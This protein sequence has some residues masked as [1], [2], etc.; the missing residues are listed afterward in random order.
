MWP[1][2]SN[3]AYVYYSIDKAVVLWRGPR[4]TLNFSF[5]ISDPR[6]SSVP[7]SDAQQSFASDQMP[8]HICPARESPTDTPEPM[9]PKRTSSLVCSALLFQ[10][11]LHR[12]IAHRPCNTWHRNQSLSLTILSL[13]PHPTISKD[14]GLRSKYL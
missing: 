10:L 9:C 1:E 14:F 13:F 2:H 8:T 6:G 7:T 11:S 4:R 3:T 5:R 12:L